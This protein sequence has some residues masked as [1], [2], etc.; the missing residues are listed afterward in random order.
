MTPEDGRDF[1]V[2]QCWPA[3]TNDR[4]VVQEP[5]AGR[6]RDAAVSVVGPLARVYGARVDADDLFLQHT[7]LTI[8]AKTSLIPSLDSVS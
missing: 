2:R 4:E 6:R 8:V 5:G 3:Y 1:N 7:Y